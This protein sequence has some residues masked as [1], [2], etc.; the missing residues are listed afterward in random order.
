MDTK[1]PE[2]VNYLKDKLLKRL[3]DIAKSKPKEIFGANPGKKKLNFRKNYLNIWKD[4]RVV[5]NFYQLILEEIYFWSEWFGTDAKGKV[6]KY[7]TVLEDVASTCQMPKKILFFTKEKPKKPEESQFKSSSSQSSNQ[8]KQNVIE[9]QT[10]PKETM[11]R[12][13]EKTSVQTSSTPSG[14][15]AINEISTIFKN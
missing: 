12:R 2:L 14:N 15:L 9:S 6:T 10:K 3:G 11:N 1:E 7:R 13:E 4:E 5:K 8:Q